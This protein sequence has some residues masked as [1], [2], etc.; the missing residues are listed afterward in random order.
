ME[1]LKIKFGSNPVYDDKCIKT[2]M[3]IYADRIN[4]NFQGKKIPKEK[5]PCECL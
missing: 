3:K 2:K 5:A 1:T 4:T